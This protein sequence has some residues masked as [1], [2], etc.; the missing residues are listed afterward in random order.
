MLLKLRLMVRIVTLAL[1]ALGTV[2][3]RTVMYEDPSS[4]DRARV[5][6]ANI[7]SSGSV[8]LFRY[9]D[10]Q[11]TSSS[12]HLMMMISNMGIRHPT[13]KRLGLPLWSYRDA[14]ANEVF[15]STDKPFVGMFLWGEITG[16]YGTAVEGHSAGV[17]FRI[18]F[19]RNK[20]YEVL[21]DDAGL[22]AYELRTMPDGNAIRSPLPS[23]VIETDGCQH[24]ITKL[25]M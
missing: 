9:D 19:E 12:E 17:A 6:F 24:A 20:D 25:R 8:H 15:I 11:C 13:P 2:G 14:A 7:R 5:R 16:V 21:L 22:H 1:F 4:G 3:C 23:P 10:D 18:N